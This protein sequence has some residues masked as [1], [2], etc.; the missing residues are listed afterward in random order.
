MSWRWRWRLFK[1]Y[2]RSRLRRVACQLP[3]VGPLF[4][5]AFALEFEEA[6]VNMTFKER[7]DYEGWRRKIYPPRIV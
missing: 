1:L 7:V 3:I 2:T 4:Y 6:R 5:L